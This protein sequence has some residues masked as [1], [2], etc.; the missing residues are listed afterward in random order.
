MKSIEYINKI[1]RDYNIPSNFI[2]KTISKY[3]T[4][5]ILDIKFNDYN[6]SE[7]DI[8][9]LNKIIIDEY[10]IEYVINKTTFLDYEFYIDENVLIPRPETED[11]VLIS[12]KIIQKNNYKTIFDLATGSGVIGISLKLRNPRLNVHISD[13]SNKALEVAKKN[14]S[15]Y[16][17]DLNIY[18]ANIFQ[19]IEKTIYNMDFIICNPPY[20]ETKKEFLNSSIKHEPNIALFAGEDG[21]DFFRE[22]LNYQKILKN[23]TMIFETTEFNYS[24]TAIILSKL[25][26]IDII[27]DSFGKNRFIKVET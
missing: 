19:G 12:E 2:I 18:Q 15:K 11:L 26:K 1:R 23:K 10:P 21:Q 9:I 14:I 27:K 4:K 24:K 13:I 8:I 20:V 17:L 7:K 16:D 6:L 25:G 3:F 5:D 22:L